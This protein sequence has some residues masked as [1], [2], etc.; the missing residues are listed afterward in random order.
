MAKLDYTRLDDILNYLISQNVPVPAGRLCKD[1]NISVRTLRNDI[2]QINDYIHQNG[3]T[4]ELIRR[5]GYLLRYTNQKQFKSFW[6]HE[7]KGTFLFTSSE[8]RILFLLRIFLTTENF[9]SKEY[10]IDTFFISQNTL[11]N[12]FRILKKTLEPYQISIHNKSNMGYYIQAEEKNIR[13]AIV[14]LIFQNNLH[15]FITEQTSVVKDV[16]NNIDY[17]LFTVI[18][19]KF[20]RKINLSNTDFFEK[21]SFASLLLTISR[22]KSAHL[23]SHIHYSGLCLSEEYK[24]P[25]KQFISELEVAFQCTIPQEEQAYILFLLSE[26]YPNLISELYSIQDN[27]TLASN[28]TD[29]LITNLSKTISDHWVFDE[30]LRI[31]LKNHILRALNILVIKGSRTNPIIQHV[32]N[33]FPY[34]F[35][36]A[37]NEMAKIETLFNISFSE[38]EISYIALYFANAI[39]NHKDDTISKINIAIICGTGQILSSIIESKLRRQFL[40]T[41]GT[42]EKLSIREFENLSNINYDLTVSTVPLPEYLNHNIFYFD[43]SNFEQNFQNI[44]EIIRTMQ[45]KHN[46][47]YPAFVQTFHQ[48]LNKKDLLQLLAKQLLENQFVTENFYDDIMKREEISNTVLDNVVAIPHPIHHSVL[49]STI[50]VAI[51]PKGIVWNDVTIKF[52][53]LLAIRPEDIKSLEYIYE[54]MLDFTSSIS[55]Q[56]SLLRQQDVQTLHQIFHH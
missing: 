18:F 30:Q 2:K 1:L 46:L 21:N 39:E 28:I 12:D 33:N 17:K 24:E 4:I 16:C 10:L 23:I 42:V 50:S 5:E 44:S 40:N 20:F 53:F 41:I 36:L 34:A 31:N 54:R 48:K 51:F 35:E 55:L 37:V 3:A 19:Y 43:I 15:H 26:N 45:Y 22:I 47:F 25:F 11:Y 56:E 14:D 52:V 29:A 8:N 38:D 6:A 7:D 49:K 9:I 27:D 13:T 32:E